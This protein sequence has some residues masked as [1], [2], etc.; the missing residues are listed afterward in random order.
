MAKSANLND[1]HIFSSIILVD[2]ESAGTPSRR[3][4]QSRTDGEINRLVIN[5]E[6]RKSERPVHRIWFNDHYLAIT[7][8]SA[9]Q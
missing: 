1:I 4:W 2:P 9:V 7:K 8:R 5:L 3:D 6:L